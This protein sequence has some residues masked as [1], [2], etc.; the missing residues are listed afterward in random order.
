MSSSAKISNFKKVYVYRIDSKDKNVLLKYKVTSDSNL[1]LNVI[2]YSREGMSLFLG[3][4]EV[5]EESDYLEDCKAEDLQQIKSILVQTLRIFKERPSF[6]LQCLLS[7]IRT[8]Y[9]NI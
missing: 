6:N 5:L 4:G 7:V 1:S 3:M 8:P 2:V 9:K